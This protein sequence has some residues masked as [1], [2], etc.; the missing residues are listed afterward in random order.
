M[1]R[2]PRPTSRLLSLD[3]LDAF[4]AEINP[5]QVG[6]ASLVYSTYLGGSDQDEA[7]GIAVDGSGNAYVTGFTYS[8]DFP[9]Q[10]AYQPQRTPQTTKH[11]AIR[12]AFLTKIA[13]N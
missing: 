8:L 1:T 5:S 2:K 7:Y 6:A 9:T 4:V 10:N 11:A 3:S 12:N 13:F